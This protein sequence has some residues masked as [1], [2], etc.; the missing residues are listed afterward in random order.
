[1]VERY[2]L[3]LGIYIS[4]ESEMDDNQLAA[5]LVNTHAKKGLI[6]WP[7]AIDLVLKGIKLGRVLGSSKKKP[8][9]KGPGEPDGTD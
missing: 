1:M 6:T 9:S 2:T 3:R 5:N 7:E 8:L 4:M